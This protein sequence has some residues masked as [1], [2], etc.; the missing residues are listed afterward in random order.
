MCSVFLIKPQRCFYSSVCHAAVAI[1]I[2]ISTRD[3]TGYAAC[4]VN[5]KFKS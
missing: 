5:R 1:A 2:L 4:L 3:S